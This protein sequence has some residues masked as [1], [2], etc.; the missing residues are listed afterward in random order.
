VISLMQLITFYGNEQEDLEY[1]FIDYPE[2][3]PNRYMVSN[4]GE[5]YNQETHYKK[6]L[7]NDK[8]GYKR[9]GLTTPNHRKRFK[10]YSV[11]K[12]VAH[13]FIPNDDPENNNIVNHIDCIKYHNYYKNLEHCTA[14]ENRLH[15]VENGL[16]ARGESNPQ[17]IFSESLV[18]EICE[19]FQN[20]LSKHQVYELYNCGSKYN[21]Q[22][23]DLI[24]HLYNRNTW[25]FVNCE[26]NY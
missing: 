17:N 22:M 11:H 23:Y 7:H 25:G 12:L 9:V 10:N 26:Y 8:D 19:Y 21:K 4:Y 24:R 14:M 16:M 2:V 5:V 15:A 20:G 6:N 3:I 18:R 1:R 13:Q